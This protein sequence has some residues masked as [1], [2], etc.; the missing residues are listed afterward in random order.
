MF[1]LPAPCPPRT[2][3]APMSG[4][5]RETAQIKSSHNDCFNGSS[6]SSSEPERPA[7]WPGPGAET[8]LR[9]NEPPPRSRVWIRVSILALTRIRILTRIQ[10]RIQTRSDS[11]PDSVSVSA[12]ESVAQYTCPFRLSG[13]GSVSRRAFRLARRRQGARR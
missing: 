10:T 9:R 11:D 7:C 8:D 12:S 6:S 3:V 1:S 4:T 5:P 2:S 13:H